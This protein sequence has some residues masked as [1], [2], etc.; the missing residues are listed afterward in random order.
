MPKAGVVKEAEFPDWILNP[1]VVKKHNGKWIVYVDFTELNKACPKDN[2]PLPRIDQLV[3]SAAGHERI[4]FLDAYFDYHQILLFGP[5]QENTAF[6]TTL[7][8]CYYKV[9][10]FGLKNTRATYQRLVTKIFKTT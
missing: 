7:G 9:I 6:I 3:D 2:F 1:V 5:D 8:Q 10:P 4:S